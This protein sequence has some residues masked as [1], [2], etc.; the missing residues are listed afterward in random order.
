MIGVLWSWVSR[1]YQHFSVLPISMLAVPAV[2]FV[3]LWLS[4]QSMQVIVGKEPLLTPFRVE[5]CCCPHYMRRNDFSPCYVSVRVM[6]VLGSLVP[7]PL[8]PI[9]AEVFQAKHEVL[10]IVCPKQVVCPSFLKGFCKLGPVFQGMD[11]LTRNE[12]SC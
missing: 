12:T 3:L 8:Y 11:A 5:C 6:V 9:S 2:F 7:A 1:R 10:L 4:G